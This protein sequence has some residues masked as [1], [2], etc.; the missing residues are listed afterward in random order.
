MKAGT[1]DVAAVRAALAGLKVS[2]IVG[3]VEMRAADHQLLRPLI[4]VQATEAGEG[5]GEIYPIDAASGGDP[6]VDQSRLQDVRDARRRAR[7]DEP[8][9]PTM[10][11]T[12][13]L[14]QAV[15]CQPR[16]TATIR[17]LAVVRG[18]R[19]ATGF[20]VWPPLATLVRHRRRRLRGGA[21]VQLGQLCRIVL[22]RTLGRRRLRAAQHS[23]VGRGERLRADRLQI[24][25]TFRRRELHRSGPG[26]RA[27]A[28]LG[29][30]PDLYRR[31]RSSRRDARV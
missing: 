27:S 31:G 3:D 30:V 29:E 21:G 26:T 24:L 12:H 1:A 23:L 13:F 9:N 28:P 18:R 10:Q 17:G 11:G 14:T 16:C 20:H 19:S 7:I 15:D 4:V 25:C 8:G 22:R 5:K 2:T 6:T